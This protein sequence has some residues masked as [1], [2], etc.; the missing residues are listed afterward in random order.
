MA[1]GSVKIAS[2]IIT[3]AIIINHPHHRLWGRK[4]EEMKHRIG[5]YR[6][7]N[8]VDCKITMQGYEISP[9]AVDRLKISPEKI[10]TANGLKV[11]ADWGFDGS[12]IVEHDYF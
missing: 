10:H 9:H 4:G 11:H 3:E 5:N 8:D 12:I 2:M 6:L 7:E 1:L